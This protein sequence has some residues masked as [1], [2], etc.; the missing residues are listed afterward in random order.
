M[1]KL[2]KRKSRRVRN[3]TYSI[4][5][6][7]KITVLPLCC[8]YHIFEENNLGSIDSN[9]INWRVKQSN[10]IYLEENTSKIRKISRPAESNETAF[11]D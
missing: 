2:H 9:E 10:L 8:Y 3:S 5:G 1:L 7:L 6:I 4:K 11:W